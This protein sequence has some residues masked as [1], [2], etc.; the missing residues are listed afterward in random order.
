VTRKVTNT[1]MNEIPTQDLIADIQ[2]AINLDSAHM[3]SVV[4]EFERRCGSWRAYNPRLWDSE[5][6]RL[7]TNE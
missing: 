7:F 3:K 4:K 6:K 5:V 1:N 2:R